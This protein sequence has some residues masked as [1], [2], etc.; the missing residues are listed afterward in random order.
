MSGGLVVWG[1]LSSLPNVTALFLNRWPHLL[2]GYATQPHFGQLYE[3]RHLAGVFIAGLYF[4]IKLPAGARDSGGTEY[5]P[6]A[7]AV[8][9]S[10]VG[11][12]VW[13]I[14]AEIAELGHGFPLLGA[15]AACGF[16]AAGLSFMARYYTSN[17]V[18]AVSAVAR[19]LAKSVYRTAFLGAFLA[20]YGLLV[21]PLVYDVMWFAPI[22][23]WMAVVLF[24]A[25]AINRMRSHAR[26]QVLPEGG[27]PAEWPHWS[28]HVQ[29]V[30]ER[31][32]LRLKGLVDL[33]KQYVETGRW[34]YL[35][36]YMLG[37]LLRNR[38]PLEEIPAVFEPM[39]RNPETSTAWDPWPRKRVRAM[40]GRTS[41][42]AESLSRMDAVLKRSPEPLPEI[43]EERIRDL[44][45]PFVADGSQPEA[46][47]VTL[48]AAYWQ[49]GAPLDLAVA[50]WFPVLT[51]TDGRRG[52]PLSLLRSR[53][54]VDQRQKERRARI[55]DAALSHLFGD[56]KA[57]ELPLVVLAAPVSVYDR[58]GRYFAS[59]IPQGEAIEVLSEEGTRWKGESRGR[60]ADLYNSGGGRATAHS[61]GRLG[62]EIQNG[63]EQ[64]SDRGRRGGAGMRQDHRQG[65]GGLCRES[66]AVEE[67]AGC[68]TWPTATCFSKT[69]RGWG[70]RCWRRCSPRQL[71]VIRR[72]CSSRPTCSLRTSWERRC[73]AR[74]RGY[75]N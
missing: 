42:L 36:R 51:I 9:Y 43:E 55:I 65:I 60:P 66:A 49:K 32:D 57:G 61:A 73:G 45:R 52:G 5:M 24:A 33:Q 72:G 56:G 34:G 16:F 8:G 17:A 4:V 11:A 70:R 20:L 75:S 67:V 12:V 69:T 15:A 22:Y 62:P 74:T 27:P 29:T 50:L 35:W 48:A 6:L 13:L 40:R 59:N 46:L 25:I 10:T 54:G 41:A 44:S 7:K 14:G 19:L 71:A 2:I 21:R 23:E 28:R 58:L 38:T 64:E 53:E 39:R 18:W 1:A 30:E 63:Q 3:E 26:Q 37:L 31:R 47:A 68:G